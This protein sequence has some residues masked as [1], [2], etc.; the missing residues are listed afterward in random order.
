MDKGAT[1]MSCKNSNKPVQN[2]VQENIEFDGNAHM[3]EI[4]SSEQYLQRLD[5]ELNEKIVE[6]QNSKSLEN[7]A[8]LMDIIEAVVNARGST[9]L[10][11]E[12][13]R[14]ERGSFKNRILP[15]KMHSIS[16]SN[17]LAERII[18]NQDA[19][20][21]KLDIRMMETYF[22]LMDN[23]RTRNIATD[24]EYRK[25]FSG[26][27]R[28]RFVSQEYRDAFFKL[29]E[30]IKNNNKISF[31]AVSTSLYPVNEKHEFSFISKMLHTID[32]Q[33]PIYDSQV[34]IALGIHR[35]YQSNFQLKLQQDT[36]ILNHI[37][38]Q[39]LSLL[40]IPEI[41]NIILSFDNKLN[42][43]SMSVEKKLDF[44]LWALGAIK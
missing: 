37:S 15:G 23:L 3:A 4:L 5:L 18:Q 16:H 13:L 10:D 14:L 1:D 39:Y 9:M 35:A 33:R 26:Y 2:L 44:I 31:E 24:M 40:N 38:E 22:W 21:E 42:A 20:F 19:I 34:D 32:P 6:Y 30:E 25:K 29:F 12:Q 27:Y 36:N 28:M 41:K 17:L 7:L 11:L 8:D 43:H